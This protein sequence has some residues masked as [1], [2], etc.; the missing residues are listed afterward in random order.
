MALPT[1]WCDDGP[2]DRG[3]SSET[4]PTDSEP[5]TPPWVACSEAWERPCA[6]NRADVRVSEKDDVVELLKEGHVGETTV[7]EESSFIGA[8]WAGTMC[9]HTGG[10]NN[11][12]NHKEG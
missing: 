11:D 10:S 4:Q 7:A 8:E 9:T 3:Q 12:D 1:L 6:V 5:C 2:R